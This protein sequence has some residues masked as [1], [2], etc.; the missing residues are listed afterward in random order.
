MSIY[1]VTF[2]NASV[3]SRAQNLLFERIGVPQDNQLYTARH[4]QIY[5]FV[6]LLFT[7]SHTIN[8]YQYYNC[9][10]LITSC[11]MYSIQQSDRFVSDVLYIADYLVVLLFSQT[12]ENSILKLIICQKKLPCL[13]SNSS[14]YIS[15]LK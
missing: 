10:L 6:V 1:N 13:F 4:W 8:V 14:F 2:N 7:P 3:I 12:P 15:F 11:A 5:H 9:G